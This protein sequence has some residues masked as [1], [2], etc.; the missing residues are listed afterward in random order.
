MKINVSGVLRSI[1]S[2]IDVDGE[3]KIPS[4]NYK[5]DDIQVNSPVKVKGRITN[6]GGKLLLAGRIYADLNLKCSRCLESFNYN[7]ESDF[8]E[9]LSN[10]SDDEDVVHFEGDTIELT[11]IIVNN[12]LLYL[13]MKV[14]CREDCKG[15]CPLCG[16]NLNI[17][18]CSCT[19]ESLDP[20]LE[21]LKKFLK[22]N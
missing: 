13:P 22:D 11:D 15:L 16:N 10:N 7:F 20:R 4:I 12:I 8:E 1:N 9:E 2:S 3:I 6:A 18:R 19:G 21:V 5:G 14:V 17:G